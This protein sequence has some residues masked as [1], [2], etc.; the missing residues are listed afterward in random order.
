MIK[1]FFS[2]VYLQSS[3]SFFSM[4][5]LSEWAIIYASIFF[6]YSSSYWATFWISCWR[7]SFIR[8]AWSCIIYLLSLTLKLSS[9]CDYSINPSLVDVPSLTASRVLV[10]VLMFSAIRVYVAAIYASSYSL[11][12]LKIEFRELMLSCIYCINLCSPYKIYFSSFL[13][14][15][16]NWCSFYSS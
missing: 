8:E 2:V 4:L 15:S 11:V 16:L 13:I 5:M 6:S 9:L 10:S 7:V 1:F 14:S 12:F 3:L